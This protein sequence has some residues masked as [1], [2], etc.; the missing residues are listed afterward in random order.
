VYVIGSGKS[1]DFVSPAFFDGAVTIGVN[2]AWKRFNLTYLVRKE[3]LPG[4]HDDLRRWL[5]ESSA[6]GTTTHFVARGAKGEND[7]QNA[8]RLL[9]YCA[10][11][12]G[13]PAPSPCYPRVVLFDHACHTERCN[14]TS[15][16]ALPPEA[17]AERQLLVSSSTITTAIHLAALMG[18]AR[19][20]L[21]GH[22]CGTLDGEANFGGY[23]TPSTLALSHRAHPSDQWLQ[24]ERSYESWL[25]GGRAHGAGGEAVDIQRD[26]ARLR[27][28]L[29][30][31]Y[32]R[33]KGVHGLNPFVGLGLEGHRFEGGA[34]GVNASA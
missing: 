3:P 21:V 18:A 33:L 10:P 13:A 6:G 20:L 5:Q 7:W 19:I 29:Q 1:A 23:H 31:R 25:R 27:T 12:G 11:E 9:R 30:Q 17:L 14:H 26:S 2:Q 34:G 22:D 15:V 16:E 24:M 4:S 8:R 28:L 32:P